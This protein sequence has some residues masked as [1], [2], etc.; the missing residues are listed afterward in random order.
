[1]HKELTFIREKPG[2]FLGMYN[3]SFVALCGFITGY[4]VGYGDGRPTPESPSP[5]PRELAAHASLVPGDF[6]RFVTEH[7][8]EQFPAGGRGW[9]WFVREHSSNDQEA[10]RLFFELLD[11]YDRQHPS[12]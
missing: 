12:T 11:Q 3:D 2:L 4:Q 6:H 7:Y 5:D 8:G 10:F 1:M 9:Q